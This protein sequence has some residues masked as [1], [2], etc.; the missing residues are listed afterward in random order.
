M[1]GIFARAVSGRTWP[2]LAAPGRTQLGSL[3]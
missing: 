2:H 1:I 3:W